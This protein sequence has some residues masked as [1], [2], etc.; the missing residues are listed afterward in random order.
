M[1]NELRQKMVRKRPQGLQRYVYRTKQC[2]CG[3]HFRRVQRGSNLYL[4]SLRQ[5]VLSHQEECPSAQR[6]QC[7]NPSL[8]CVGSLQEAAHMRYEA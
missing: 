7:G 1:M 2:Q 6:S 8:E 3:L 4:F 5:Q